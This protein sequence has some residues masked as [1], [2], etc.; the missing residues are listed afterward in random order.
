MSKK[1]EWTGERFIPGVEA[2]IAYEHY[3]RY[4]FA[5]Q[6]CRGKVVLD[7]PSGEG[8]GSARLSTVAREVIGVDLSEQA[9]SHAREMYI[10]EHLSFRVGD[11]AVLSGLENETLDVI[12]CFEG[13]E[14][15]SAREQPLV[16]RRFMEIL[17]PDGVLL[18]STPNKT[19][20][21]DLPQHKNE[22]HQK[23]FYFGE[24]ADFLKS[25]FK[26]VHFFGQSSV[27][28]SVITQVD[29]HS[30]N[31]ICFYDSGARPVTHSAPSPES[32]LFFVAVCHKNEEV[33]TPVRGMTLVDLKN[34]ATQLKIRQY[35]AEIERLNRELVL[36]RRS[37]FR[38]FV[39]ELFN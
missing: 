16:L 25:E 17:K 12:T 10:G 34:T 31:D 24:Y 28:C 27:D 18:I 20:Y 29:Q 4:E 37:G 30:V 23:E 15:L 9:I 21:S 26:Q 7:A 6:F 19:L 5:L 35:E 36:A 39:R 1:L 11:V 2:E 32:F 3:G 13:I 33:Q 8:F 22:F 38:T 14:H